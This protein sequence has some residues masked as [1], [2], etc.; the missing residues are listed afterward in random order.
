MLSCN[1][2]DGNRSST[3]TKL[4]G[5]LHEYESE[6]HY[7]FSLVYEAAAAATGKAQ[8]IKSHHNVGGL[9]CFQ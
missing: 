4:D 5:L 6:Y 1:V 3:I 8:V 7:L 9:R 2:N